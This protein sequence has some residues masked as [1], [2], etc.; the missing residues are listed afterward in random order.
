MDAYEYFCPHMKH[1]TCLPKE[2]RLRCRTEGEGEGEEEEV[3]EE[4]EEEERESASTDGQHR[5][6]W[7]VMVRVLKRRWQWGQWGREREKE[8]RAEEL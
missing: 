8:E 3:E 6:T 5:L 7:A 1:T 2:E 4:E